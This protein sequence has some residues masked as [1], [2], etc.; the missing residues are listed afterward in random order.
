M[1]NFLVDNQDYEGIDGEENIGFA[2]ETADYSNQNSYED[3]YEE[4]YQDFEYEQQEDDDQEIEI[5][6]P[7]VQYDEGPHEE[8][9]IV[10]S[11]NREHPPRPPK[12]IPA[13]K[14]SAR[15]RKY[16]QHLKTLF[17]ISFFVITRIK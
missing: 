15:S 12:L 8:S 16:L 3:E 5:P 1:F 6:I 14:S 10:Y 13:T 7:E 17:C 11:N 4:Q 9:E 2:D